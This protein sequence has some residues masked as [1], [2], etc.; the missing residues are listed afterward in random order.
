MLAREDGPLL[1]FTRFRERLGKWAGN[2]HPGLRW[3][4][5]E[6]FNCQLCLGVWVSAILV[7]AL[8]L[9]G[10]IIKIIILWLAV[11][12]LQTFITLLVIKDE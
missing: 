4:L 6:L 5:A 11:S 10:I 9:P 7:S 8:I 3:T 12:G 1:V 2:E